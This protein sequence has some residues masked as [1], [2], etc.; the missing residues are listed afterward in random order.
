MQ[1]ELRPE[2]QK[3]VALFYD[4]AG[5]PRVTAKGVGEDAHAL[6]A[7]AKAHQ[8][9]LCNNAALVDLLV[10]LETGESV[11]EAL[12]AAVAHIIAF[13]YRVQLAVHPSQPLPSPQIS[14]L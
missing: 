12:Y 10:Q 14:S 2:L 9:P 3:A 7:Q 13:A 4:G 8:V 6:I 11:P 5:A 1:A